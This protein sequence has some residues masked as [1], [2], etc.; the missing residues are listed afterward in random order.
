[1]PKQPHILIFNPDGWRGD[2]LG[3]VGNPA[4]VTPNLD[5]IVRTDGVSFRHAF[6]QA[7]VCTPSRCSFMSGWYP[8][9]RGH[10]TMHHM[11]HEGEP[12]LLRR[13]KDA[14]YFVWWAGKN[15]LV[16]G[17]ADFSRYCDVYYRGREKVS[18]TFFPPGPEGCSAK[19]VPDTFSRPDWR[20]EPGSDTYY[21]FYRGRIDNPRGGIVHDND[22]DDVQAAIRTIRERPKDRPMCLYLALLY[23]H[24]PY[25]VE[26]PWFS[27]IDRTKLPPRAPA[28]EGWVGKPSI[29][30]GMDERRGLSG[31]SE[32]RW[33]ELRATYYGMCARQDHLFGQLVEALVEE[34][35][36]DETAIFML[37]D[38]GW[39]VGDYNQV[40]VVQ[41][42]FE[43]AM[44][45]VP[46]VVKPP[47]DVP[48]RPGVC[49]ALVELVDF[50]ATVEALTGLEPSH[51]H[52]GRS[53]L[54][55]VAGTTDTHRDA[56][57]SE[58]GRCHGETHCSESVTGIHRRP[59][60]LYWPRLSLQAE[61]GPEHTKAV[62]I[63]TPRHKYVRRLYESD[64]L[65]D[66]ATDPHELSNRIADPA[67]SPILA[68]LRDRLLTWYL[69]TIDTVPHAT[70][71]R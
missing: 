50:P 46:L 54:P 53:L 3:H 33:D 60:S 8:H 45:R 56:V 59:E 69:T 14:G 57:F 24:A 55:L 19:K 35:I 43:D 5:R 18:G 49:D 29:L 25:Q 62:M 4:A 41:N 20:G 51:T 34:G 23:P 52:F 1:M 12:V 28:P 66:L 2:V 48:V 6:A 71:R 64:E 27:M 63:R 36:Y 65:Y 15:D 16:P 39:F 26:E 10:R 38:H 7:T 58:G 22:F 68:T 37:S 61:D 21:S 40:E 17:D 30:K 70:D 11:M 67:L 47:A 9:V 42:T 32:E 13:L 44:T 31:W